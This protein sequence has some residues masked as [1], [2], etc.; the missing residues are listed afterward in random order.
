MINDED[1]MFDTGVLDGNEVVVET[2]EPVVDAVTTTSS[3]PVSAVD[4]VTTASEV[5]TTASAK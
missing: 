3:I 4:P 5:V 2:K 1:L